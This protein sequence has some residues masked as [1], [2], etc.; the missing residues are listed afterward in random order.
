M[1]PVSARVRVISHEVKRGSKSA[2]KKK[3]KK[4]TCFKNA[5]HAIWNH[6]EKNANIFSRVDDI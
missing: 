6:I 1:Y 2:Q 5:C 3:K 4:E